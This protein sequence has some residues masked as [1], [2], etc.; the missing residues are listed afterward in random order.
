M[1]D[2][3]KPQDVYL[4]GICLDKMAAIADGLRRMNDMCSRLSERADRI[5]RRRRDEVGDVEQGGPEAPEPL[6]ARS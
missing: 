5:E 1:S 4:S 3:C 6:A 2:Y